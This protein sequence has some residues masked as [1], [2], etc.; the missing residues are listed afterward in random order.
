M[1]T[2]W[3]LSPSKTF[4]FSLAHSPL[5]PAHISLV[6]K[7]KEKEKYTRND[8]PS[9]GQQETVNLDVLFGFPSPSTLSEILISTGKRAEWEQGG[10]QT[11]EPNS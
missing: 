8:F 5:E 7:E 6:E 10:I 2:V 4:C 9:R 1:E 11:T 3:P